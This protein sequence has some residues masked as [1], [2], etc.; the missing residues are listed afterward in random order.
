MR[1]AALPAI[2]PK[3]LR[4][5]A[6][7]TG[8]VCAQPSTAAVQ[9][10]A[11]LGTGACRKQAEDYA[12]FMPRPRAEIAIPRGRGGRLQTAFRA[13]VNGLHGIA[14]CAGFHSLPLPRPA[15][16]AGRIAWLRIGLPAPHAQSKLAEA[17][18]PALVVRALGFQL[19]I[20]QSSIH[21]ACSFSGRHSIRHSKRVPHGFPLS[22]MRI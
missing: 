20:F 22:W 17:V 16:R 7:Y 21:L 19:C 9:H 2:S 15:F 3:W 10:R 13:G 6:S 14:E 18:C 1:I 11:A 12:G 4:F 8:S 5:G